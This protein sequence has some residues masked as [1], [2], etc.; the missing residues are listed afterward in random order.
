[1]PRHGACPIDALPDALLGRILGLAG[2]EDGCGLAGL[3]RG[4]WGWPLHLVSVPRPPLHTTAPPPPLRP[5]RFPTALVCKRW[6]RVAFSGDAAGL[7][8]SLDEQLGA[9]QLGSHQRLERI[10][11]RAQRTARWAQRAAFWASRV[12]TAPN[13]FRSM[14]IAE[15]AVEAAAASVVG[16][17]IRQ[18]RP[19]ALIELELRLIPLTPDTVQGLAGFSRLQSLCLSHHQLPQQAAA[20]ALAQLTA[21]TELE[22]MA[23]S[24]EG[25]VVQSITCLVCLCTLDL[26]ADARL[27]PLEHL[28]ALS[29][30]TRLALQH[31]PRSY[32]DALLVLPPATAF[33]ALARLD[34]VSLVI[35]ASS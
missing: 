18:L 17:L 8:G 3:Y 20:A 23:Q 35:Q 29:C 32:D 19:E 7:W 34:V 25:C 6:Q 30:L 14:P 24:I 22:L 13:A 9:V 27:P 33:P 31:A 26:W 11:A 2:R 5:R 10:R 28:T 16:E 12:R 21:L 4:L 15:P 1:M